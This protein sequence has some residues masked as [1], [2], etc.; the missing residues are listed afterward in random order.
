[1]VSARIGNGRHRYVVVGA[2]KERGVV[3]GIGPSISIGTRLTLDEDREDRCGGGEHEGPSLR[4]CDVTWRRWTCMG[5]GHVKTSPP[6]RVG[7]T[8]PIGTSTTPLVNIKSIR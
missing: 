2:C 3:A 7:I 8:G 1:V 6:D 4:P 5:F